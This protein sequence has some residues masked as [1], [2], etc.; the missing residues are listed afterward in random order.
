M[1]CIRCG[2]ID[3]GIYGQRCE[4]CW[5]LAQADACSPVGVPDVSGLGGGRMANDDPDP[6]VRDLLAGRVLAVA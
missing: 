2:R 1:R 5:S 3:S 6:D 4:D